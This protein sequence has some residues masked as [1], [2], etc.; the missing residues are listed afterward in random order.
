MPAFSVLESSALHSASSRETLR[1]EDLNLVS[2]VKERMIENNLEESIEHLWSIRF[3]AVFQVL[4]YIMEI[5]ILC[6]P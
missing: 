4:Y 6:S 3:K 1:Q 5:K 2:M